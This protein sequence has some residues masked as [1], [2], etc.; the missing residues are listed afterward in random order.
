MEKIQN[1]KLRGYLDEK[2]IHQ[3]RHIAIDNGSAYSKMMQY[4]YKKVKPDKLPQI[5]V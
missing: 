1:Y 5:S 2:P 3:K 4:W